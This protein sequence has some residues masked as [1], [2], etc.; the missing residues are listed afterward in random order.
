MKKLDLTFPCILD[1]SPA[2]AKI[3]NDKYACNA[4]PTTYLIDREGKV[5]S[6][7]VGF[8]EEDEHAKTA[9][10]KLGFE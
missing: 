7:W 8:S 4:V 3:A 2:A 5:L 6:A 10:K 1:S 9:L